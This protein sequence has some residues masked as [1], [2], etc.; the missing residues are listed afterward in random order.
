MRKANLVEYVIEY[1][2]DAEL[3]RRQAN[4][5]VDVVLEGLEHGCKQ[6]DMVQIPGFG[7]FKRKHR[8]ARLGPKPGTS[9]KIQI[10]ESW[11]VTFKAGKSLKESMRD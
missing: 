8:P 5:I 4:K 10:A 6:D 3:N 9:E 1:Y 2:D 11:T 7:T